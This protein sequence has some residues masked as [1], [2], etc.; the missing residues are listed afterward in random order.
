MQFLLSAFYFFYFAIVGIY[1]IFLPKVL[2][3]VGYSGVEIGI[4]FAT[5][6]LVR[7]FVPFAFIKGIKL[8]KKVFNTALAIIVGASLLFYITLHD[9]YAL[10]LTNILFGIGLSLILPYVEVIALSV[11]TKERYGRV[12]LFGSIGF[13]VVALVLV[14]FLSGVDIAIFYLIFMSIMTAIIGYFVA[15]MEPEEIDEVVTNEGGKINVFSHWSLWVGLT[16]MQV[17][18]GPFYNFFTIYETDHGMG[19]DM[20]I[21]L[22]S[23][24]VVM[25]I[26]MLF[27]QGKLLQKNILLILQFTTFITAIRW[28]LLFSFPQSLE[29]SFLTQSIHAFSFALFHSA[30]ISY[31]FTL[32]KKRRLAQ[33]FFLGITYG[34]GGF[35]GALYSGYV[36]EYFT[37]YLFLSSA[38]VA[39]AAFLFIR[40]EA[41]KSLHVN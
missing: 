41:A 35:V 20:T 19:M 30:A 5:A 34:L 23:F 33:Q 9:F 36:Y 12:R 10:I 13:I 3:I 4:V 2:A 25:E 16:L 7:F 11:I 22:W 24:G 17:G 21:Y 27:F 18:F 15:K 39:F 31:L 6:P 32:Y 29:I 14:K 1:V 28:L 37:T 38:I 8:N 40:Y 26:F